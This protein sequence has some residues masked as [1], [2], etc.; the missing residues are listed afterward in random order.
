MVS[1]RYRQ[2]AGMVN[3]APIPHY[4]VPYFPFDLCF[5]WHPISARRHS[6][7]QTLTIVIKPFI[8]KFCLCIKSLA[9][10]QSL[11]H[12]QAVE[13]GIF[14]FTSFCL[15]SVVF[16]STQAV[17]ARG[18][19]GDELWCQ[20]S[21]FPGSDLDHRSQSSTCP[22]VQYRTGPHPQR[23]LTH[24]RALQRDHELPRIWNT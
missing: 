6:S 15:H 22:S 20:G 24:I 1:R 19:A 14:L 23:A 13:G 10:E 3:C 8:T 4:E 16:S 21:Y 17:G 5:E 11:Q 9:E 7:C 12:S 2:V 18:L